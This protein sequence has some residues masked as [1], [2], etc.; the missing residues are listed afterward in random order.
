MASFQPCDEDY[1]DD[2]DDF[3]PFPSNGAQM[4]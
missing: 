4:E 3:C 2:G 1:D